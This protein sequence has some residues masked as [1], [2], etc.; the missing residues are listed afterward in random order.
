[1]AEQ[2]L[3]GWL[4]MVLELGPVGLFF[5]T[6][7]LLRD[8]TFAFRGEEYGGFI[9]A[10]ALFIPVILVATAIHWAMTGKL[11]VMQVVTAVLVTVFGGLSIWLNDERFFKMKP[12]MIYGLF[13]AILFAGLLRGRSLLSY[14]LSEVMPLDPEGWRILTRR[15]AWLFVGL[16]ITNEVVWRTM[17]TDAWVNLRTFGIPAIMF[18]FIFSQVAL[19]QKHQTGT[20]ED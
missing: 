20:P 2:K 6:Y 7:V 13:A 9:V 19:M 18:L 3:P 1:M 5:A 12:T 4:K 10:T 11:S 16:A 8:D 17:S 14:V 15:M